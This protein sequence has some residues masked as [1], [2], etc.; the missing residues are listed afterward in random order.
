MQAMEEGNEDQADG[1]RVLVDIV[2]LI[3][4]TTVA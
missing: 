4:P 3:S 1:R 2:Q